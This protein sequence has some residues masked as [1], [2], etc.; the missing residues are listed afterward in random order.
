MMKLKILLKSCK[1]FAFLFFVFTYV[2]AF[3]VCIVTNEGTPFYENSC[4]ECK[5]N[6]NSPACPKKM[7]IELSGEGSVCSKT[8]TL[9][10]KIDPKSKLYSTGACDINTNCKTTQQR[11]DFY[12]ARAK[13]METYINYCKTLENTFY[14]CA[15]SDVFTARSNSIFLEDAKKT[16]NVQ[17]RQEKINSC[18]NSGGDW[19]PKKGTCLSAE[20]K[21]VIAQQQ[22][23]KEKCD[24]STSK[25]IVS[26]G[27][28]KCVS[29]ADLDAQKIQESKAAC[30]LPNKWVDNDGKGIC[31]TLAQQKKIEAQ[32]FKKQEQSGCNA[33]NDGSQWI[34][35]NKVEKC[36]SKIE[37]DKF[38]CKAPNK[39]GAKNGIE[40]CLT[41]ED[42]KAQQAAIDLD[43]NNKIEAQKKEAE[44]ACNTKNDG[45]NPAVVK[46]DPTG[47]KGL[48]S[49]LS[50]TK[51]SEVV[52]AQCSED[53]SK[54][55]YTWDAKVNNGKGDCIAPVAKKSEVS[56]QSSLPNCSAVGDASKYGGTAKQNAINQLN[57][58]A[59]AAVLFGFA[60]QETVTKGKNPDGATTSLQSLF[61]NEK[62][63]RTPKID[64]CGSSDNI[65]KFKSEAACKVAVE[66]FNACDKKNALPCNPAIYG[67][68]KNGKP[69]CVPKDPT[70]FMSS[71]SGLD[72]SKIGTGPNQCNNTEYNVATQSLKNNINITLSDQTQISYA[73]KI[74]KMC[75]EPN[76]T[77]CGEAY[78][79]NPKNKDKIAAD[80]AKNILDCTP[81]TQ[82]EINDN[83]LKSQIAHQLGDSCPQS[84]LLGSANSEMQNLMK[85]V[86]AKYT[87]KNPSAVKRAS[88]VNDANGRMQFEK[89]TAG[90]VV[91]NGAVTGALSESDWRTINSANESGASAQ[92]VSQAEDL[93]RTYQAFIFEKFKD[94]PEYDQL[95]QQV[96]D[97]KNG[98]FDTFLKLIGNIYNDQKQLIQNTCQ[99][100]I[101]ANDAVIRSYQ[102][103]QGYTS[104]GRFVRSLASVQY[105]SRAISCN[106]AGKELKSPLVDFNTY[107]S[108]KGNK[109]EIRG[110]NLNSFRG[111]TVNGVGTDN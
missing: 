29:L 70:V 89:N 23:E 38:N 46:W 47:N 100:I 63:E 28:G 6:I 86:V 84:A 96:V 5:G 35:I 15:Y 105:V 49:C 91:R 90:E 51:K 60:I 65:R 32:N 94:D 85:E 7:C 67:Y 12:S 25:W 72:S 66:A 2:P 93:C 10:L 71:C 19:L 68:R 11:A 69:I 97:N 33:K 78:M 44:A 20:Q 109:T 30:K 1:L 17:L 14:K 103:S 40:E 50:I 37:I 107:A 9:G 22:A 53:K 104:G 92:T 48:G 98:K 54:Q 110:N 64:D 3:A 74:N 81:L 36:Y 99:N 21:A 80:K 77:R 76:Y 27:V 8:M 26:K 95:I 56:T 62:C 4:K 108:S 52:V 42:L 18:K 39:W 45:K 88:M 31:L 57:T 59:S 43:K 73:A 111:G 55:G 34:V 82:D 58:N 79:S 75:S 83:L 13:D 106:Q 24:L 87:A 102:E 41:S 16:A 101:G 61:Q